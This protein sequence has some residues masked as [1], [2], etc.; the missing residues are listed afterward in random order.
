MARTARRRSWTAARRRVLGLLTVLGFAALGS[1]AS[2]QNSERYLFVP[3][4]TAQPSREIA[5]TQL[6]GPFEIELRANNQSALGNADAAQLFE[7][8]H[9]SEPVKLNTDE[10]SRLLRSV[11][12][13]A[14]H[15]AL[16][17]LPQAQQAMEGVYALSGP[18]RDYLNREAA[19][20]RKIFDT[21]LMTAYLWERDHKRQQA[22][23]Q[24]LEC[25]RNFP[26][27][28]P[29]GRAY[30]PELRDVFEQAKLQLSQEAATTLLVQSKHSTGCG[31]RLNGI[32]VGKSP[33]SFSDVRAGVMRVQLECQSGVAGRIHSLEL[34]PGENRLEIDPGFDSVIHSQGGLWLQYET[35]AIRTARID[36]DLGQIAKAI[37]AVKVIGLVVDGT[38]YPKVHVH[39]PSPPRD[40]ASL[41]YS[42]GE[43]YNSQALAAALKALQPNVRRPQ[44]QPQQIVDNSAPIELTAPPPPPATPVVQPTRPPEPESDQN[45]VA[46]ALLAGAGIAGLATGWILY[47]LRYNQQFDLATAQQLQADGGMQAAPFSEIQP[48]APLAAIGVGALVLSISDYFWPPDDEGV[49]G[50][51]WVMGGLGVAVV[52]G[53]I[54]IAVLS[55]ECVGTGSTAPPPPPDQIT[56]DSTAPTVCGQYWTDPAGI[57][58]PM[59]ALHGMPLISLPIAYAIRAALHTDAKQ[60]TFNL[61]VPAGGGISMQVRGVF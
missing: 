1:S 11:S 13:A 15:L 23:R 58:G 10:M 60:T 40:V 4:L 52:G 48:A 20:A 27:F 47:T 19:R 50:W 37:G 6:T 3:V 9:S 17:E 8:R 46:G 7:T 5:I 12:Q 26:G 43:G 36:K 41:S 33:M 38:S 16:G 49:P 51:A 57:F 56:S 54:A 39:A 61:G 53:G 2:A 25:S 35:N 28:R 22:L 30:P 44:Q 24:M 29:E 18:A 31:V 59:I 21:C 42:I 45:V 32:E 14:R 55:S 34:K